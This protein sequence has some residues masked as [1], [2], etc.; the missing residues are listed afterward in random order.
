[1]FDENK[2]KKRILDA[3]TKR[4]LNF[5]FSKTTIDEIASDIGISK[6]TLYK[7]FPSKEALLRAQFAF[8]M[9]E[10]D[11]FFQKLSED[12]N[13]DSIARVR[14]IFSYIANLF[15]NASQQFFL[16]LKRKRPEIWAEI[17]DFRRKMLL[18][19]FSLILSQGR[20]EG[21]LRNDLDDQLLLLLFINMVQSLVNPEV[22]SQYP[23]SASQVFEA[24]ITVT[25][26]GLLTAE[27]RKKYLTNR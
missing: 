12:E 1:M 15:A 5:G 23:F 18:K 11:C 19:N 8:Y 7:I 6:K 17:N 27:G 4:F 26:E 3:A 14:A 9:R 13:L 16:D 2:L 24:I 20:N 22:L 21:L 10:T 25:F